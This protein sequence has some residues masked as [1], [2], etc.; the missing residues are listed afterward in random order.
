ML[1]I[2][3][4]IIFAKYIIIFAKYIPILGPTDQPSGKWGINK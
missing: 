4:L 1:L 3:Y 2:F